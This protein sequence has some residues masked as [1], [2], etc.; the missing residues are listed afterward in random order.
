MTKVEFKVSGDY[1]VFTDFSFIEPD[2]TSRPVKVCLY[3]EGS[4]SHY[5]IK[6][7]TISN[8]IYISKDKYGQ[9]TD[10]TD[11]VLKDGGVI[12]VLAD[13]TKLY[14]FIANLIY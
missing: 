13:G 1:I 10:K 8:V 3:G 6:L 14:D 4:G 5:R 9:V 7:D 12:S 11:V 2:I